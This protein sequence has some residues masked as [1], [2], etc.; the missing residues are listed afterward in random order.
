MGKYKDKQ[1][2]VPELYKIIDYRDKGLT[3]RE[4][5]KAMGISAEGVRY[6]LKK[7]RIETAKRP[8]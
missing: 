1:I 7:F 8:K 5:G 4:I 2:S 3:L 6:L